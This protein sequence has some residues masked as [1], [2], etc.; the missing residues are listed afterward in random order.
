MQFQISAEGPPAAGAAVP[1]PAAGRWVCPGGRTLVGRAALMGA[2]TTGRPY[3][4]W[5][6]DA[7]VGRTA[8]PRLWLLGG[9]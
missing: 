1:L 3:V 4:G 9:V 2:C 6:L 7:A 8:E 5:E